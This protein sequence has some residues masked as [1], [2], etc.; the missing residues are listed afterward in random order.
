M[1]L[2]W[3]AAPEPAVHV[4]WVLLVW[5]AAQL[6]VVIRMVRVVQGRWLWVWDSDCLAVLAAAEPRLQNC[7]TVLRVRVSMQQVAGCTYRVR[8]GNIAGLMC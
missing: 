5:M 2:L 1:V 8:S 3:G 7:K 4:G 6:E